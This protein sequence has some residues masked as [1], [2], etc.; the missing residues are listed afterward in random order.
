MP[1]GAAVG[2]ESDFRPHFFGGVATVCC[3]LF[4][5]TQ[6]TAAI[7][8][9]KDYQQLCVI[10]QVVRD[11]NLPIE[12]IGAST[13]REPDGLALSSRNR[14]LAPDERRIAPMIYKAISGVADGIRGGVPVEEQRAKAEVD[15]SHQGFKVDYLAV[16]DAAT[17]GPAPEHSQ[18]ELRV[19]VAAWL[20]TTRLIDNVAAERP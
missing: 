20:G 15:L 4:G 2:L 6:A 12:I 7:F 5:Q 11:L 9:E 19:L 3:K 17:L 10:R 8:G 14:Y 1:S 13:I 16:R 18:A